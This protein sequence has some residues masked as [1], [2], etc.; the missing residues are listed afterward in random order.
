MT[1]FNNLQVSKKLALGFGFCLALYAISAWV[2]ISRMQDMNARTKEI[3]GV[4]NTER[5][6]AIK[7]VSDDR[8][9][10]VD[11][12][13]ALICA[14]PVLQASAISGMKKDR[15]DM[16]ADFD[17]YGK[18]ITEPVD[19]ANYDKVKETWEK[20]SPYEAETI[21]IATTHD[22]KAADKLENYKVQPLFDDL[23]EATN[24]LI[25]WNTKRTSDLATGANA[26][27]ESARV[28]II[29]FLI[30]ALIGGITLATLITKTVSFSMT[31]ISQRIDSLNNICIANLLA[32]I[33]N[34]AKG[35]LDSTITIGS[36]PIE[37]RGHDEFGVL[38]EA[39]NGMI[40][41]VQASVTGFE[42]GQK[43]L[44]ALIDHTH[45]TVI[46]SVGQLDK[47]ALS[48]LCE[49]ISALADGDLTRKIDAR[50]EK[51]EVDE[52]SDLGK[53]AIA[54]NKVGA[55]VEQALENYNRSR[56]SLGNLIGQASGA[57][58]NI[59]ASAAELASGN[60]DLSSR[61]A[62]QAS[63]LEETAASMEEM[64]G[65]VKQNA[66]NARHANDVAKKAKEVAQSGGVIVQNAVTAMGE[67]GVAAKGVV[68]IISVIDEIAFQTNLLALNA[69]VEAARVGEQGKGFAV[70]AA[71]VRSLAGRSSTA[72]K[73]I[74]ALVQLA[75]E[76]VEDGTELVNKSGAQLEEI[77]ASVNKVAEI[78]SEISAASQEQSVGIEQV[79]K[80]VTQMDEI[81]QQNAALVEEATASSQAMSQQAVEL[82][83]L[84]RQFKVESN[85]ALRLT[86]TDPATQPVK[87]TTAAEKRTTVRTGTGGAEKV[88]TWSR[89]G[90]KQ[91][92]GMDEF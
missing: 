60:E 40:G 15:E 77:V 42:R 89:N 1:W 39:I 63:S 30:F 92:A 20:I 62:E 68:D 48:P 66:E 70:V 61:T 14:D 86:T 22:Y 28:T 91:S 7:F 67:V 47:N 26:A 78:V 54:V 90:K 69:A 4:A 56:E 52:G 43:A 46:E 80:A 50:I 29:V 38:S 49:G 51:M 57:A 24:T 79:N 34:L 87:R 64:T 18:L 36:K 9:Y 88:G 31:E 32:A 45:E 72:A 10:R 83:I 73:E 12:F 25:D 76:K 6:T 13:R 74:K 27:F 82:Q 35:K 84:V 17:V 33:E 3:T 37:I 75:A 16:E 71:E 65:T 21:R 59:T 5:A 58:E 23:K 85:T 19:K 81:T 11:Q 44:K 41:K 53:L 55:R 2:A 8:H